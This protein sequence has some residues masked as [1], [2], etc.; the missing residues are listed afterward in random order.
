MRPGGRIM[1]GA[2]KYA[3]PIFSTYKQLGLEKRYDKS[4]H[5]YIFYANHVVFDFDEH[6]RGKTLDIYLI[7][8][9]DE[10]KE[11]GLYDCDKVKVYGMVSGQCGWTEKYGWVIEGKWCEYINGI[12]EKSIEFYEQ[13]KSRAEYEEKQ[14]MLNKRKTLES[15][16]KEFEKYF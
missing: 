12:L 6:A 14:R 15:R 4:T 16:A 9:E 5:S 1:Q 2:G 3:I 13:N 7:E 11:K 8:N 10:L